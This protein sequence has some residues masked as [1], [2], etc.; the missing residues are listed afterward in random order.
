MALP[1]SVSEPTS[2][3]VTQPAQV[4]KWQTALT[5]L[6]IL[7]KRVSHAV[8]ATVEFDERHIAYLRAVYIRDTTG[9]WTVVDQLFDRMMQADWD[10]VRDPGGFIHSLISKCKPLPCPTP[11]QEFLQRLLAKLWPSGFPY[12]DDETPPGS[13]EGLFCWFRLKFSDLLFL[14]TLLLASRFNQVILNIWPI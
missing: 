1:V 9:F 11:E 14:Q 5:I 13:N 8:N 3:G 10:S 4:I 6:D 2:N 12:V 7:Q